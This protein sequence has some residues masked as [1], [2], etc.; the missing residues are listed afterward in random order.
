[1]LPEDSKTM[2]SDHRVVA[3]AVAVEA[4]VERV[5]VTTE[6]AAVSE[7]AGATKTEFVGDLEEI[8]VFLTLPCIHLTTL[9]CPKRT[10]ERDWYRSAQYSFSQ[11]VSLAEIKASNYL[12]P[13]TNVECTLAVGYIM[14]PLRKPRTCAEIH[15]V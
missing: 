12:S 14:A 8:E 15:A 9:L 10:Q 1:M 13:C 11:P 6:V 5:V 7:V 3:V 4:M 2:G